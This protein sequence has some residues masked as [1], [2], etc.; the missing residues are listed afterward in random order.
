MS[1]YSV[2]SLGRRLLHSSRG[3][4]FSLILCLVKI[5]CDRSL[6]SEVVFLCFSRFFW[7]IFIRFGVL[8]WIFDAVVS[9][10][11]VFCSFTWLT[12]SLVS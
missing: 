4:I 6:Q 9:C 2:P 3:K 5:G 10:I 7:R 1:V 8:R 11:Y 12:V